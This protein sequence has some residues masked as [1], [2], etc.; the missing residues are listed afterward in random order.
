MKNKKVSKYVENMNACK[1]ILSESEAE[2]AQ[3]LEEYI[4]YEIYGC[5][6]MDSDDF[7]YFMYQKYA[8]TNEYLNGMWRLE[9]KENCLKYYH[10]LE[11]FLDLK[12]TGLYVPHH[13]EDDVEHG[14]EILRGIQSMEIQKPFHFGDS[15]DEHK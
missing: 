2:Y 13:Y 9:I 15:Q 10:Y 5:L 11:Q 8:L 14:L 3:A 4:R 1:D 6:D 12:G 7:E